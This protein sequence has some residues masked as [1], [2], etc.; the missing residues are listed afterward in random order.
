LTFP[1]VVESSAKRQCQGMGTRLSDLGGVWL[2]I[3]LALG[4]IVGRGGET[5]APP[6]RLDCRSP[7]ALVASPD[8]SVLFVACWAGR[9]VVSV[10]VATGKVTGHI[11]QPEPP[12]GLALSPDGSRLYVTC[13]APS[14]F[15]GWHGG[16]PRVY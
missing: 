10:D 14:S 5:N 15:V 8:G 6:S 11:A 4:G 16:P 1:L 12:T 9:Q 2:A 7:S 3:F 13:G